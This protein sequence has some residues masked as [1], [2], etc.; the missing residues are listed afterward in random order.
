MRK[1]IMVLLSAAFAVCLS[2]G[3]AACVPE[4]LADH[5]YSA[6]WSHTFTEHYHKCTD[7]GCEAKGSAGAHEW[8]LV[9]DMIEEQPTC[10]NPGWG[11]Y[12]CTVCGA[13]KNDTISATGG[14]DYKLFMVTES[15]TCNKEGNELWLCSVCGS[16]ENRVTPATGE[17]DF[18]ETWTSTP[19]GHYHVCKVCGGHDGLVPHNDAEHARLNEIAPS[20]LNDGV[21]RYI[22]ECGFVVKTEAIPNETVAVDFKIIA[23]RNSDRQSVPVT[24]TEGIDKKTGKPV[25]ETYFWA[26]TTYPNSVPDNDS[27]A[28][29]VAFNTAVNIKG[30]SATLTYAAGEAVMKVYLINEFTGQPTLLDLTVSGYRF[31]DGNPPFT[32]GIRNYDSKN[33]DNNIHTFLFEYYT[34]SGGEETLRAQRKLR[35][36]VLKYGDEAPAAPVSLSRETAY[37]EKKR[38]D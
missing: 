3:L 28:Y 18:E 36:T 2:L 4:G 17:H 19:E 8:K 26:E 16:M 21:R 37:I 10:G 12:V 11:R 29:T 7:P 35:V 32:L 27:R 6:E 23:S 31:S 5:H 34:I 15:A 13:T 24:E 30:T 9:E 14:H 33:P 38:E 25:F 22:C 1:T 20:G